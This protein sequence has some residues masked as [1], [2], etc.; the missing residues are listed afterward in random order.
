MS[1]AD[2]GVAADGVVLVSDPDDQNDV[3]GGGCVIEELGH[4]RLHACN[5]PTTDG[6]E[7]V[8]C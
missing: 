3:E 4:D 2:V 7:D 6:L 1:F 5:K 8:R